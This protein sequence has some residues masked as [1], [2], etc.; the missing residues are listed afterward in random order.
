MIFIVLASACSL[1]EY[2]PYEVRLE[3]EDQHLNAKALEKLNKN[4]AGDTIW[5]ILTADPQRFY[6]NLEHLVSSAN[7]QSYD[8]MLIAGDITEYGLQKEY[9]WIN[10]ILKR[11]KRPYFAVVGNHDYAGEG[12][13]VFKKMFG[14]LNDSFTYGAY[15]FILHDT[16][17]RE[18]NFSGNVPNL[19]WLGSELA[20]AEG[21]AIVVGHVPPFSVDFDKKLENDYAAL[22]DQ[23]G[24]NLALFAHEH[25]F[26]IKQPYGDE[27]T[28]VVSPAL[29][30]KYY[31][32]ISVWDTDYSV[33]KIN[34]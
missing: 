10:G 33:E 11:L 19:N 24:V 4:P 7:K 32:M 20:K 28:Y 13:T 3:K 6:D 5:F 18:V 26:S 25:R 30:T 8:F 1:F 14:P 31:L 27:V 29:D 9:I 23:S 12:V 22:L 15:T 2:H 34:Y 16:N 21:N 17:S